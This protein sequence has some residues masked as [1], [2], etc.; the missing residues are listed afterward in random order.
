MG[1]DGSVRS[2]SAEGCPPCPA[3]GGLSKQATQGLAAMD[4]YQSHSGNSRLTCC[5]FGICP[6]T[7]LAPE[8]ESS[9]NVSR[10][11]FWTRERGKV[12]GG[13]WIVK[14]SWG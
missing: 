12:T 3:P 14:N 4:W 9:S 10:Q 13:Y 7:D 6:D 11:G 5:H 8:N 1:S 2:H